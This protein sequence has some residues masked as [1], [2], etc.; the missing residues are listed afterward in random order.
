MHCGGQVP[1]TSS[2]AGSFDRLHSKAV[3]LCKS[4]ARLRSKDLSFDAFDLPFKQQAILC[5]C[6]TTRQETDTDVF[7]LK[8]PLTKNDTNLVGNLRHFVSAYARFT[9]CL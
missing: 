5:H 8:S 7:G 2:L 6:L 1:D 9:V 4:L 3:K